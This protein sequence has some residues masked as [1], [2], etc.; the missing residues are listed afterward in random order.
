MG[1]P[2]RILRTAWVVHAVVRA[3]IAG[4]AIP[5]RIDSPVARRVN[6][7]HR[8]ASASF[9]RRLSRRTYWLAVDPF[10]RSWFLQL[11]V[12]GLC[13]L[14]RSIDFPLLPEPVEVLRS[15][16][17]GCNCIV[18]DRPSCAAKVALAIS[19]YIRRDVASCRLLSR[20]RHLAIATVKCFSSSCMGS[21]LPVAIIGRSIRAGPVEVVIRSSSA[22]GVR[23]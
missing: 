9:T 6:R 16:C 22:I 1:H 11:G 17:L 19:S 2:V 5:V 4:N 14:V 15:L 21:R 10:A 20:P 12:T 3:R 7:R 8:H 23:T 13:Q 18:I